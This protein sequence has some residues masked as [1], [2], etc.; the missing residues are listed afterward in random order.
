MQFRLYYKNGW[1]LSNKTIS[2]TDI[3]AP[4]K[5]FLFYSTHFCNTNRARAQKDI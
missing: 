1:I 3:N 4:I 2:V 5:Y